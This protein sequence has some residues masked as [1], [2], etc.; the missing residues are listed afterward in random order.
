MYFSRNAPGDSSRSTLLI[1]QPGIK[2]LCSDR[3]DWLRSALLI[4]QARIKLRGSKR[5]DW[6]RS[7]L[8]IFIAKNKPNRR[9]HSERKRFP[10]RS[11]S[12]VLVDRGGRLRF[13]W[14]DSADRFGMERRMIAACR[15]RFRSKKSSRAA[16]Q[17]SNHRLGWVHVSAR[18][19]RIV[20]AMSAPTAR[21]IP[22]GWGFFLGVRKSE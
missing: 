13:L 14:H 3:E 20:T 19:G 15:S 1:S 17:R 11:E 12:V 5:D 4:P 8:L 7:A 16:R 21:E 2:L 10:S 9:V 18:D 6:L 22:R